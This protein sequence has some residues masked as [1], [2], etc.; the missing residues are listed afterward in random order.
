MARY[1]EKQKAALDALMKDDV[2]RYAMEILKTEGTGA[3]TMERLATDVGVSRGT[4]YNY[5]DDKDSVIDFMEERTF[6]SVLESIT[7]V[8]NSTIR[9]EEKLTKIAEWIFTAVYDDSALVLALS[10]MKHDRKNR[11]CKLGRRNSAMRAIE[12]VIREGIDSGAFNKLSPV[13][14]SEVFMGAISGMI[15]SMSLTGEFY[16]ADAVVPTLME[17]FLGGLRAS[18]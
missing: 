8:A 13:V 7:K 14:V 3:L 10:P 18:D 2:Y 1:S 16:R 15:E 11:A 5:F 6:E 9:A 4:L 12:T 17:L